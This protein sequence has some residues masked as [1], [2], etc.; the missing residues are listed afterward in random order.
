MTP[1]VDTLARLWPQVDRVAVKDG[2]VYVVAED[3]LDPLVLRG[4]LAAELT[5]EELPRHVVQV[6]SLDPADLV[7]PDDRYGAYLPPRDDSERVL[8]RVWERVLGVPKLGVLDDFYAAGGDS[9]AAAG[10]AVEAQRVFG[11]AVSLA[12][13]LRHPTVAALADEIRRSR[14]AAP[15]PRAAAGVAHP[16]SPQQRRVYLAQSRDPA[17]V[18][19]HLPLVLPLP[20]DVDAG[21]L[22]GA[23]RHVI[24]RHDVLRTAF[25]TEAGRPVQ[26]VLAGVTFELPEVAAPADAPVPVSPFDLAAP[27]L[28]RAEL[29]RT[30]AG[31][32]L[33]L[34][35]HHIVT[36]GLSL[37]LL[38]GEV[39]A[40]YAGRD[41]PPVPAQYADYA[42]WVDGREPPG[43]DWWLARFADPPAPPRLP[44]D[45]DR[46]AGDG[47]AATAGSGVV[48]FTVDAARTAALRAL[49]RREG[50]TLFQ[51]LL[52]VYATFLA[53]ATGDPGSGGVDV[54]VGT[55]VAGRGAPGLDAAMGMFVNTVCLRHRVRPDT[56]FRELL[57]EV[58]RDV[59]DAFAHQEFPFD[60]L[61]E[62]VLPV[63][64]PHR[65]P[66]F[67]TLFAMQ[68]A[69]VARVDFLGRPVELAIAPTGQAMFDLDMQVYERA[70][71]LRVHWAYHAGLFLPATVRA[72]ADLYLELLDAVLAD[73]GRP[74][75]ALTGARA[76]A[77]PAVSTIDIDL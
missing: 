14:A 67:D 26:R 61:V 5:D 42:A 47:P 23:F 72:F 12:A 2:C 21:R 1:H 18:A 25:G 69:E 30:P 46:P 4:Q 57:D 49:A 16:L 44:T 48:E 41:L 10:L 74:V 24:A 54:T 43:R 56:P 73:P 3:Y 39:D 45:A 27:P 66:L 65:H 9:L 35:L 70:D 28:L 11:V 13:V 51:L 68:H 31:P 77:V 58:A 55:P 63:R 29:R 15:L 71:S 52:A 40:R 20:A 64:D 53:A 19:Y 33:A 32:E 34:E 60:N 76:A 37:A 50:V 6:D 7:A 38:L 75:G 36:D 59:V 8:V 22:A 17:S 62:A